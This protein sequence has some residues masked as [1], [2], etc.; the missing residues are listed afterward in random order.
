MLFMVLFALFALPLAAQ[1]DRLAHAAPI[2][3]WGYGGGQ[4]PG[5]VPAQNQRTLMM[6]FAR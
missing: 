2:G 6:E 4:Q 1:N 5:Y 3:I